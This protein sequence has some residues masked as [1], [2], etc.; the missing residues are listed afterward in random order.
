VFP[1][2]AQVY[3]C[4]D[5]A[6]KTAYQDGPC[7]G[8]IPRSAAPP[9]A[10][11]GESPDRAMP[12][13]GMIAQLVYAYVS[14]T[15]L[16]PDLHARNAMNYQAWRLRNSAAV[17]QLEALP[18]FQADLKRRTDQTVEDLERQPGMRAQGHENCSRMLSAFDPATSARK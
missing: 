1:A 15:R 18:D 9:S 14:C 2:S 17:S 5:K 8:S 7:D 12:V 16:F 6:G 11:S 10:K 13:D 4:T 3:K